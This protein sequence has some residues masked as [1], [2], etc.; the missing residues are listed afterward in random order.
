MRKI[1]AISGGVDSVV[2][3]HMMRDDPE[4]L[5]AHVNHGI[6]ENALE[7][8][9]FVRKLAE[10]WGV[11]VRVSLLELGASASEDAARRERYAVLKDLAET[12]G[13]EIWTAHHADDVAETVII[14]L[15]RGTGW[16]GLAAMSSEKIHRPLVGMSKTEIYQYAAK[17]RLCWREDP[18]NSSLDYLRNRVREAVRENCDDAQW[19][20][21]RMRLLELRA[22]QVEIRREV[23]EIVDE[24][25]ADGVMSERGVSYGRQIFRDL[26][27]AIAAELL[28]GILERVGRSATRPQV[29]NILRD[30]HEL[31]NGKKISFGRDY[32][33]E[34]GRNEVSFPVTPS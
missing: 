30:I 33:I 20:G 29:M 13:G 34:V 26:P 28:R 16:R 22:R 3:M 17:H 19:A 5:V 4:V 11:E 15:L 10:Q 24:F 21:V 14:N 23:D 27:T 18:T 12:A 25:V 1:L 7:D 8:E 2:L 32:F 9:E 6:R 31:Q